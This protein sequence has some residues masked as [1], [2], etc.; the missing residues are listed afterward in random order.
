MKAM[1][2]R[3][4][5][6]LNV[7]LYFLCQDEVRSRPCTSVSHPFGPEGSSLSLFQTLF[8]DCEKTDTAL[9]LFNPI[10]VIVWLD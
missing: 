2:G 4:A 3:R 7:T 6:C 8:I 5:L 9:S 1:F 10:F